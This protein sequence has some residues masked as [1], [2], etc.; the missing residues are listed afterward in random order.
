MV[1]VKKSKDINYN[2]LGFKIT[3]RS[4][5]NEI[6]SRTLLGITVDMVSTNQIGLI[7]RD[8]GLENGSWRQDV[9]VEDIVV[10]ET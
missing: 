9:D 10:V 4:E 3:F 2:D 1:N 8:E 6:I 7:L 5:D